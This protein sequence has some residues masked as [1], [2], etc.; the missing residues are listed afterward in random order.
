M[1]HGLSLSQR[2]VPLLLAVGISALA[3]ELIR[4]RKLREEFAMVWLSAAVVLVVVAIWPQLLWMVSRAAGVHYQTMLV[5][6]CFAFLAVVA[7]NLAAKLS[8]LGDDARR[9]AQ[10]L[11]MLERREAQRHDRD[12][13]NDDDN[14]SEPSRE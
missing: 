11:A 8:R 6:I 9:I 2:L 4:R 13:R 3:V 7:L 10:R 12:D 1:P 14:A 5:L